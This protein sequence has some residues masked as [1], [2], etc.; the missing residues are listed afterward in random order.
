MRNNAHASGRNDEL[1]IEMIPTLF[2]VGD[3]FPG[4]FFVYRDDESQE[5]IYVNRAALRIFAAFCALVA[6][7]SRM[8]LTV[9][10]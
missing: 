8:L 1:P 5:I 4:G 3:V 7:C 9:K 2:A 10:G 6:R